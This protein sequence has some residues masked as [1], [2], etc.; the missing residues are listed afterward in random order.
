MYYINLNKT[1]KYDRYFD[2][3]NEHGNEIVKMDII[4]TNENI[5]KKKGK[6]ML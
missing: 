6:K 1:K 4:M 5:L 2:F 3:L